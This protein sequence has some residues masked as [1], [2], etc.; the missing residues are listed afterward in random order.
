M[1]DD[2]PMPDAPHMPEA[3]DPAPPIEAEATG[4]GHISL[5]GNLG[6]WVVVYFYPRANTPG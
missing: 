5:A 1:S 6:R 4:N 2:S 3:G